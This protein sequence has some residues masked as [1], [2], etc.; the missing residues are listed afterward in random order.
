FAIRSSVVTLELS[1]PGRYEVVVND[2]VIASGTA[3]RNANV[4]VSLRHGAN[5]VAVRAEAG[6]AAVTLKGKG[7]E[8]FA[9]VWRVKTV[10]DPNA[11]RGNVD[12]RQWP[13]VS[14]G[15]VV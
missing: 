14:S 1:T 4:K 6:V 11:T 15:E 9:P 12:D 8:V 5:T 2:T 7:T 10:E 3:A 13:L